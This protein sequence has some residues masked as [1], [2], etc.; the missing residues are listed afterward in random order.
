MTMSATPII[1]HDHQVLDN[2]MNMDLSGISDISS[3]A[4]NETVLSEAQFVL[5]SPDRN[6]KQ[7]ELPPATPIVPITPITVDSLQTKPMRFSPP[8]SALRAKPQ[9]MV[10]DGDILNISDRLESIEIGSSPPPRKGK[11]NEAVS[12]NQRRHRK[13]RD[14]EGSTVRME[15]ICVS[16]S[17]TSKYGSKRVV[18]PVRRSQRIQQI[19]EEQGSGD[20]DVQRLLRE[21]NY[22]YVPNPMLNTSQNM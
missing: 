10:D 2:S 16:P 1:P 4:N 11:E 12:S 14:G 6:R 21:S 20:E 13:W 7:I 18:S 9:R 17:K 15:V 8:L 22:H 19:R 5:T 3:I